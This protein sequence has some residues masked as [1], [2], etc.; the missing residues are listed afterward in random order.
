MFSFGAC[1]RSA[2]GKAGVA[3]RAAGGAQPRR[4]VGR[5]DLGALGARAQSGPAGAAFRRFPFLPAP[6]VRFQAVVGFRTGSGEAKPPQG[7]WIDGWEEAELLAAARQVEAAQETATASSWRSRTR[8]R[9]VTTS[10]VRGVTR[11]T[12]H[13]V[14]RR[15]RERA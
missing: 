4:A 6:P 7:A 15:A 5:P 9:G 14:M 1:S 12:I 8:A 10:R 13:V 3:P 11:T 2:V